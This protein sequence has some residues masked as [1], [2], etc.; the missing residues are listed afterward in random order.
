MAVR[1]FRQ[2]GGAIRE[3]RLSRASGTQSQTGQVVSSVAVFFNGF[4]VL[5]NGFSMFFV[6]VSWGMMLTTDGYRTDYL[7]IR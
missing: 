6:E 3:V 7:M 2:A 1:N 4:H 5:F